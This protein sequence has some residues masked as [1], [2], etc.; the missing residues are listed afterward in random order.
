MHSVSL[1]AAMNLTYNEN[2]N[3]VIIIIEFFHN[4]KFECIL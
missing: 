3:N 2:T 1:V 4:T